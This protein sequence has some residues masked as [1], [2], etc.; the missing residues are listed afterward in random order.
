MKELF[1]KYREIISYVFFG[2]ATTAVNYA[3]YCLLSRGLGIDAMVT[4]VLAWVA[5]VAFAY[6]VNKL[7]VFES[8]SWESSLVIREVWQFCSARLASLGLEELC[9]LV[10]CKMMGI[11]DL[12]V[13][14]GAAVLVILVNYILSKLI[15]FRK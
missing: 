8:K 12:I 10:F 15:I 1:Q 3:V 14:I 2:I 7:Y 4:N 9:L 13:K 6:I 5:A 11:D